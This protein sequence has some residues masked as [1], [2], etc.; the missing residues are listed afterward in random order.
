LLLSGVLLGMLAGTTVY[1]TFELADDAKATARNNELA[2]MIDLANE[3]RTTFGEYRYWM[4][5]LAV[6]LLRQS[7]LHANETHGRLAP[8]LDDL[9][10]K[11]PEV[12]A[13]VKEELALFQE[14]AMRAVDEYTNDQRVVGNTYFAEA[15]QHSISIDMRLATLA[16]ALDEE[17]AQARAQMID[18]ITG[19]MEIAYIALVLAVVV[20]T[21]TTLLVLRSILLPLR[22]VVHAI[23]GISAGN[24]KVAIP[25][26]EGDEI[27][28]MAKTLRL[29]RDS[30]FERTRLSEEGECERRIIATAIETIS[31]VFILFDADDRLVLCNS[32]LREFYP[33]LADMTVLGTRF[34][35]MLHATA[36]RELI[37]LSGQTKSAWMEGRL[38]QHQEGRGFAEYQYRGASIRIS[39]RRT[40]DGS[41]VAV[42]TDI[43]EL[44]ERQRQLEEAIGQ[45]EV[46]SQAKSAF[47]ANMSHELRTTLNAIIGYSE[48]L[49]EMAAENGLTDFVSDVSKVQ[50]AGRHLLRLI[51]DILDLSKIEAGKMD[52][53]FEDIDVADLVAELRP[54]VGLLL[55]KNKNRFVVRCADDIGTLHS[56]RT[57]LK[58]AILNLLG[59]A[60][61]FT[62]NGSVTLEVV[63]EGRAADAPVSFIVRDT[64][65]AMTAEQMGKLFTPFAQADASTTRRYGGTGLGLAI[66][67]RL[68]E[69]LGGSIDVGSQPGEGSTFKINVPDRRPPQYLD[70]SADR[71]SV[72]DGEAPLVMVVDDDTA[73]RELLIAALRKA[74]WRAAA[75]E[76]GAAAIALARDLNPQAITLDIAMPQ[77]DG[78]TVLTALKADPELALIPV[79]VVT[80]SADRSVAFSLGAADFKTKP[81]ERSRLN[82]LLNNLLAERGKVLLVD[83]D[84]ESREFT[85]RQLRRVNV[86]V[87][88]AANGRETLALLSADCAPDVILLD[89]LMPEMNGFAVLDEI[90]KRA[91]WQRIPVVIL[92]AKD[93]S[94]EERNLIG[95]RARDVIAKASSLEDLASAVRRALRLRPAAAVDEPVDGGHA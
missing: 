89:L 94:P 70:D 55:E 91:D 78:W 27:G 84:A 74:G 35:D 81:I 86:E 25:P 61:K 68:C 80:V 6:S 75:V 34:R 7:E 33:E 36:N 23:D 42:Y 53:Y 9:A 92:T 79:I 26:V 71:V 32:K 46:A 57:K 30:I 73:S 47:L 87:I 29:F 2:E 44:K 1:L 45:A 51:S 72:D 8:S 43:T 85:R 49:H 66:T 12:A 64:G 39:E 14:S 50:A 48:I 54:M 62:S 69:L 18:N 65:I 3:V 31:E 28:A 40:A 5:D 90:A 93:L 24:L 37:D 76:C 58:Q 83:D 21:V 67:Q 38:R 63:R 95:A 22:D 41:T 88:E 56:D 19:T 11:R 82:S 16:S 52:V 20:G 13:A 17:A 10:R 77:M 59:N 4:T 15:R 60:T